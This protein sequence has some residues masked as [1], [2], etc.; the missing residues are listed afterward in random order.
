MKEDYL[1]VVRDQ[2]G[3]KDTKK[4][5]RPFAV[6]RVRINWKCEGSHDYN[7]PDFMLAQTKDDGPHPLAKCL[8]PHGCYMKHNEDC[9]NNACYGMCGPG[10]TC[11]SSFCDDCFCH[12][13]CVQHDWWCSC[14]D[15]YSSCCII[16]SWT[17]CDGDNWIDLRGC[18][19][20]ADKKDIKYYRGE[21]IDISVK[22]FF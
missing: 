4:K 7:N 1:K 16:G 5:S 6:K 9:S 17:E 14:V 15:F 10:C 12:L 22:Y 3:I 20:A 19:E 13:G 2:N 21:Y 8:K 11:W 18:Q